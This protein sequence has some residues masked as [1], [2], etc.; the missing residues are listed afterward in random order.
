M[1][2]R[3]SLYEPSV[4]GAGASYEKRVKCRY[5][6]PKKSAEVV[7]ELGGVEE[8]AGGGD[9]GVEVGWV[10]DR[11]GQSLSVGESVC[12]W[13]KHIGCV[14]FCKESVGGDV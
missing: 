13:W 7:C 4:E 6:S 14:R 8:C 3:H 10:V 12:L 11:W 1:G 5:F 9:D 2:Q